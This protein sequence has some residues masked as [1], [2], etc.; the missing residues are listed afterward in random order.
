MN[1]RIFLKSTT[2]AAAAPL[3]VPGLKLFGAEAPSNKLNL[4]LI[5]VCGRG[6]AFWDVLAKQKVVALCDV[7]EKHLALGAARFSKAKH[8]IDWREC[9]DHKELDGVIVCT[10]DHT[11]ALIGNWAMN[12]GLHVYLEKPMGIAIEEVRLLREAYIKNR[13]KLATQVG[14]QRHA[15]ANFNRVKE[16]IRD[17]VIGEL[18]EACA[19]GNR[20]IRK[21]GYPKAEGEPPPELHYDFWLAGAPFHPYSPEYFSRGANTNCLWW[22]MYWDF[23]TGQVGDM[24]CH[25]M[26]L[27]WNVIDATTPTSAEAKGDPFNPEVT[28][29]ELTAHFQH[30]AN[31]WRP[32]I[33]VSWYQGGAMPESPS[34][35]LDLEKIGH[36]AMFT[37]T[38]GYLVCDFQNRLIIP[39][40]NRSDLTYYKPR[41]QKD[42]IPTTRGFVEE[43]FDACKDPAR[44]ST[45]C[46]FEYSSLMME[47]QLLGLVAYRAGS[48]LQY[49]GATGQVT[50]NP[51]ANELLRRTYRDGWKLNG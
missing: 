37:G 11:H 4:A 7:N 8:Y 18:E 19:W 25:T 46:N 10:P 16:L 5:G 21:P 14:T 2:I 12:R 30:P 27:V 1:R 31:Q 15:N 20:Q 29:V 47:Q 49:D 6:Q 33:K 26:D 41:G 36:G 34:K 50:N 28:P 32:A 13:H 51:K 48:K 45:S 9:L 40:S 23:G 24:G 42:I 44:K 35:W 38:E 22:N 3:I 17:G 39:L 43:W